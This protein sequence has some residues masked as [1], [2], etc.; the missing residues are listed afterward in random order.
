MTYRYTT[1]LPDRVG[2]QEGRL[3]KRTRVDEFGRASRVTW[4][5]QDFCSAEV[6]RISIDLGSSY[7]LM[8]AC[9]S[10]RYDEYHENGDERR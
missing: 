2:G 10:T 6:L 4:E 1:N 5:A 8:Y 9:V 3:W 7:T